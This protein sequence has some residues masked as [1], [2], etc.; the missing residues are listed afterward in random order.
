M[1]FGK[2]K[3]VV[4]GDVLYGQLTCCVKRALQPLKAVFVGGSQ[5][6]TKLLCISHK[7]IQ[8]WTLHITVDASPKLRVGKTFYAV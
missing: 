2:I 8:S 7:N 5:P 4:H 3:T 1:R 6:I